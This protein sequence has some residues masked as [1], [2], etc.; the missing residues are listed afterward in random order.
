M[1]VLAVAIAVAVELLSG[2]EHLLGLYD[3]AC[4]YLYLGRDGTVV[5]KDLHT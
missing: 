2:K 1:H 4:V 3:L 5:L